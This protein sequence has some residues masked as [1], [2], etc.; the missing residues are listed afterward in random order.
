MTIILVLLAAAVIAAADQVLKFFIYQGLFPDGRVTVIDKL[1]TLVYSENRGAAFGIFQNGTLFFILLTSALIG[2]F[3]YILINHKMSGKLFNVSVA[4]IIGG[5]IGNLIDRVF[6]GYV[7]D[8]LSVSFFPPICNFADYCIT[9]GAALFILS[10][11]IMPDHA[12]KKK[13]AED[14]PEGEEKN[15]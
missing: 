6:R 2:V 5:G 12:K 10:I 15:E 7:I 14:L 1:F 11:L 13:A 4:M 8:Y 9:V 3:L